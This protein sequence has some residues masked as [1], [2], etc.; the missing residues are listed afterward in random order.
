MQKRKGDEGLLKALSG[1]LRMDKFAPYLAKEC[2]AEERDII[3]ISGIGSVWPLLRAHNLLNGLHSLLGHKPVVLFYP[4]EYTGQSMSLFG[5][6]SS[7]NYYRA[8]KLVP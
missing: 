7:S 1:P 4:G 5:K 2:A 3:L 6:I 8:F